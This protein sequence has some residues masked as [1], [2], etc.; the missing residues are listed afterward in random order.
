MM[1]LT[2]NGA[3]NMNTIE[4]TERDHWIV[5]Q[6]GH[7]TGHR[8]TITRVEPT[9]G[10]VYFEACCLHTMRTSHLPNLADAR[11]QCGVFMDEIRA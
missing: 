10:S 7:P 2:T 4:W 9:S 6:D 1:N 11:T 5:K 8:C 3:Q